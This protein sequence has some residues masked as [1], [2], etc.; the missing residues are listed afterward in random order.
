NGNTEIEH[1]SRLLNLDRNKTL[2]DVKGLKKLVYCI[3]EPRPDFKFST[4]F[5][6]TLVVAGIILFELTVEYFIISDSLKKLGLARCA[7]K[8]DPTNCENSMKTIFG[9]MDA[10]CVLSSLIS[11]ILLLHFMKCHR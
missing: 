10:A 2:S 1:V 5:V 4:Q 9:F 8:K 11:I 7:L 6:S 3:Y